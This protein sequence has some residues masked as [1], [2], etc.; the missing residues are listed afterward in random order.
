MNPKQDI[1]QILLQEQRLRFPTIDFDTCW[2][3]GVRLRE[4]AK[5]R[6][7]P[8]AIGL[9]LNGQQIFFSALPG[10][11]ADNSEWMRRKLNVVQ[12]FQCSSYLV[13]RQLTLKDTNLPD[14][15]AAA[16]EDYAAAGGGFP[17]KLENGLCVGGVVVSG[18]PQRQDHELVV[19]VLSEWLGQ[20]YSELALPPETA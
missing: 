12:R 1:E 16:H 5:A 20:D 8:I 18:L 4:Q 7:L 11:S 19:E 2:E 9:Q 13:Q 3:L 15:S 17:L 10:T 14:R 6:D